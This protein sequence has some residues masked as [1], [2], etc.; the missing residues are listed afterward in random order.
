MAKAISDSAHNFVERTRI[1]VESKAKN[2][3]LLDVG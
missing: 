3:F 1:D 2:I